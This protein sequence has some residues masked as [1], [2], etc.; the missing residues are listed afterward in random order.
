MKVSA[1]GAVLPRTNPGWLAWLL[2]VVCCSTELVL[3][4]SD[5]GWI[6]SARWRGLAYQY[7]AFW[8]GLLDNWRP[9]FH[10]QPWTMFGTYAF[11]HADIW[12]LLGNMLTLYVIGGILQSWTNTTGFALAYGAAMLGGAL[13]YALVPLG[14]APMVGASGALFGL[15]GALVGWQ[16]QDRRRHQDPLWP[17]VRIML[18]LVVLN[19]GLWVWLSGLL[20]WQ[21][22]LG[23][24]LAG[25]AVAIALPPKR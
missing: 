12:H 7:G 8:P 23:G 21:A 25:L 11:L 13:C 17:L 9:N 24:F 6:G 16:W 19:A 15:I 20:A 3:L 4:A 5:A 10:A 14:P 1:W 18:T 2:I 22:H